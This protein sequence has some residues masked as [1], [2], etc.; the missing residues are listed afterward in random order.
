MTT[1]KAGIG[2]L[3]SYALLSPRSQVCA[4]ARR[5]GPAADKRRLDNIRLIIFPRKATLHKC[6]PA[7]S[8]NLTRRILRAYLPCEVNFWDQYY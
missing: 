4:S 7:A 1:Q 6:R 2:G 5:V 3:Y 8:A